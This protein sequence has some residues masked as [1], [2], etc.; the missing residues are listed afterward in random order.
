MRS[1]SNHHERTT[2]FPHSSMG[3]SAG[4]PQP[5]STIVEGLH[6]SS[7]SLEASKKVSVLSRP[8]ATRAAMVIYLAGNPLYSNQ[9]KQL[10]K[11]RRL[12][13]ARAPQA[14]IG[15]YLVG[16]P[17]DEQAIRHGRGT[18]GRQRHVQVAQGL[19]RGST[20]RDPRCQLPR[21]AR[22]FES[23]AKLHSSVVGDPTGSRQGSS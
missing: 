21:F 8:T 2:N 18:R 19:S 7:P 12:S 17:T 4:C 15:G 5:P 14:D 22:Y 3:A 16:I 23:Q 10:H 13:G 1:P 9:D 11:R 6:S 20:Q